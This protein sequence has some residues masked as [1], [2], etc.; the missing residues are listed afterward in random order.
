[1]DSVQG[2]PRMMYRT[3]PIG[4]QRKPLHIRPA[5]LEREIARIHKARSESALPISLW[6][7][8]RSK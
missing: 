6:S 2:Q 8:N 7:F 1:M 5:V 3:P 4:I